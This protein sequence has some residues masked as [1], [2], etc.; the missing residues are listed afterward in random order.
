MTTLQFNGTNPY[1][2]VLLP[3]WLYNNLEPLKL[4]AQLLSCENMPTCYVWVFTQGKALICQ[5][6]TAL[7]NTALL[8][9]LN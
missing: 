3:S 1:V 7:L 4:V 2:S 9:W 6:L 5:S 8:L